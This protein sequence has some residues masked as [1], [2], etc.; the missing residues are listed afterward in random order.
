MLHDNETIFSN[1][2]AVCVYR[3][4]DLLFVNEYSIPEHTSS[5]AKF[6]WK[7]FYRDHSTI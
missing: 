6:A 4:E 1:F 7:H 3:F 2:E 5:A